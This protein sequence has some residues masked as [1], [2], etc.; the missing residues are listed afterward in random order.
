MARQ[1]ASRACSPEGLNIE[2]DCRELLVADLVVV[3][4]S[5]L[6]RRDEDE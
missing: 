6:L 2:G 5:S 4:G 3:A 1:R